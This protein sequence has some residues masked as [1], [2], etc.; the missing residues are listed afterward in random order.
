MPAI[1]HARSGPGV[2]VAIDLATYSLPMIVCDYSAGRIVR[3][4]LEIIF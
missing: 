4:L 2:V 3:P 1:E